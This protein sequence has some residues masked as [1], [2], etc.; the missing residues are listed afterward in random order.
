MADNTD[1]PIDSRFSLV[2]RARENTYAPVEYVDIP[3]A[4]VDEVE[5]A[6][7]S[8]YLEMIKRHKLAIAACALFFAIAGG[9]FAKRPQIPTYSALATIQ[10]Q[11]PDIP[12]ISIRSG[13]QQPPQGVGLYTQMA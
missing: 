1:K 3:S 8:E 7:F 4:E 13:Y 12:T 10:F 6:S 9:L 2:P 5:G 11:Q